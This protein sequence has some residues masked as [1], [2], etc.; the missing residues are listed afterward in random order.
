VF[1][2]IKVAEKIKE[3]GLKKLIDKYVCTAATYSS[4]LPALLFKLANHWKFFF[5]FS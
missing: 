2:K 5:R 3:E 4:T 1:Y